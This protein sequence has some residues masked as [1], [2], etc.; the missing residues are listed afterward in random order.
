MVLAFKKINQ[1]YCI[2]AAKIIKPKDFVKDQVVL[3]VSTNLDHFPRSSFLVDKLLKTKSGDQLELE[4]V[5][6]RLELVG[7]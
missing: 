1:S 6:I 4:L 3:T 2:H 5:R 7:V